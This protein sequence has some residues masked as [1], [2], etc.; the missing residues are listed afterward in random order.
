MDEV[1]DD[2]PR[3]VQASVRALVVIALLPVA[4]SVLIVLFILIP[5]A[6]F[7]V[8]PGAETFVQPVYATLLVV[9]S[10]L[11]LG[12]DTPAT[13]SHT[14]SAT[15]F[16]YEDS[17]RISEAQ[18]RYVEGELTEDE[19]EAELEAGLERGDE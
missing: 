16:E 4:V 2:A 8:V 3:I 5:A 1:P 12:V 7:D 19:L 13:P 17:E 9:M 6:V 15:T 18:Q 11:S 10:F 14:Q